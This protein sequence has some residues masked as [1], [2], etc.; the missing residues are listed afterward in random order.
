MAVH[1]IRQSMDNSCCFRPLSDGST[2]VI[3]EITRKCNLQCKHCM[4]PFE[5]KYEPIEHER[6]LKLMHELK[7]NKVSKIMFT[8]GEP[9]LVEHIFDYIKIAIDNNIIVDLNS[10][11]TL[12]DEQKA[13]LLKSIGITEITTSIDGDEFT[14]CSIR[15]NETSYKKTVSAIEFLVNEGISVDVV[16]TLMKLNYEKIEKVVQLCEKLGVSSITFSGLILK[17]RAQVSESITDLEKISTIINSLRKKF[18]IPIRTV[19]LL[20]DDFSICH[21]G[22]DMI[23]IDYLGNVHPCLQDKISSPLNIKEHTLKDCIDNVRKTLLHSPCACY[24]N[25]SNE[26]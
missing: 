1:S 2:R 6:I 13:K 25:N 5:N 24:K 22:M 9:L 14:H 18:T 20:N 4:V 12:V 11:L 23:G 26:F 7:E 19:R 10:N 21:K 3:F 17:G 8:G 15:N 16:C